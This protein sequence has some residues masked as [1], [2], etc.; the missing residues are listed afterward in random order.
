[1]PRPIN[2]VLKGDYTDRDV[3]KAIRDLQSLQTQST[4]TA[5]AAGPTSKA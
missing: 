2:I 4:K 3:K 5:A 1:M